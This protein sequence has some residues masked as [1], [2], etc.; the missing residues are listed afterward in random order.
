MSGQEGSEFAVSS[1][2]SMQEDEMTKQ[3]ESP[4]ELSRKDFVKGAAALAG[5]GALA[6]CA[7]AAAPVPTAAPAATCPPAEECPPC[8]T[9]WIPEKWDEEADVVVCGYGAAGMPAAIEAHDAGAE[10]LIMEKLDEPGGSLRR[11]GGGIVGAGTVVQKALGVE[12]SPDALYEYMIA[13]A[14][15]WA[16]PAL[17]RVFADNAGKNLDWILQDLGG[18]MPWEFS[19]PPMSGNDGLAISATP[20][21]FEEFGMPVVTRCHWFSPADGYEGEGLGTGWM[22]GMAGGSGLFK[23]FDDA[24]M[25]RE[26]RTMLGTGLT[27][28]VATP[29]RE[30]LGVKALSAGKTL[31]IKAKRGVMLATG[32]FCNNKD[33]IKQYVPSAIE[34][35]FIIHPDHAHGEGIVAGQAIGADLI[36]MGVERW[37]PGGGLRINTKAQ[38]IDVYGKVIPRLYAG[39]I[40]AAGLVAYKYPTCGTCNA[41]GV[42]FGRIGGTNAA[43]EEPW[44]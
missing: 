39:G 36:N 29:D 38:V 7:P 34:K 44:V 9:T 11:S 24:I 4:R 16:D 19:D 1:S 23:P 32:G 41:I 25:A 28:L 22:D 26:I 42:C 8:A 40:V 2:G 10:V 14:G 30:V 18:V 21:F 35:T 17:V 6:S 27:E 37:E 5:V 13:C 31:Y 3:R 15:G 33:M 12:D 43:A 20:V